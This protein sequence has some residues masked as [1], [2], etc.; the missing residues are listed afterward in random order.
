MAL[1]D[2]DLAVGKNLV[3][4]S[5]V[6]KRIENALHAQ[7]LLLTGPRRIGKTSL[8]LTLLQ[9]ND[10]DFNFVYASFKDSISSAREEVL[11]RERHSHFAIDFSDAVKTGDFDFASHLLRRIANEH[12]EPRRT[13]I[14]L[15][16][17]D[18]ALH[19]GKESPRYDQEVSGFFHDLRMMR[20]K[21]E[22]VRF[23]LSGVSTTS[24]HSRNPLLSG[25][26]NDLIQMSVGQ[27]EFSDAIELASQLLNH[28][29]SDLVANRIAWLCDG[30]PFLTKVVAYSCK[31]DVHFSKKSTQKGAINRLF[32]VV[33]QTLQRPDDP[34]CF[35]ATFDAADRML[36]D[37]KKI[38]N[39][40]LDQISVGLFDE[41]SDTHARATE[42][43]SSTLRPLVEYGI[44]ERPKTGGLRFASKLMHAW[45][46]NRQ[47]HSL[48]TN[49]YWPYPLPTKS[50]TRLTS[51]TDWANLKLG[52][53]RESAELAEKALIEFHR[54]DE[55]I[56]MLLG[57]KGDVG[58]ILSL[59][60]AEKILESAQN[61]LKRCLSDEAVFLTLLGRDQDSWAHAASSGFPFVGLGGVNEVVSRFEDQL[62]ERETL[63]SALNEF[64]EL[65]NVGIRTLGIG[66]VILN[67]DR[68]SIAPFA[69]LA[70]FS[71][72]RLSD[73][74]EIVSRNLLRQVCSKIGL[75]TSIG[76]RR[77]PFSIRNLK[78]RDRN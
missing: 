68:D 39:E 38:A 28:N 53:S 54:V 7:N 22:K 17:F 27:L 34:F 40:M 33:T 18:V 44:V 23:I 1:N 50:G 76:R 48:R 73:S 57:N 59:K 65:E 21:H 3:G 62:I 45:W 51:Y 52:E 78:K 31:D 42:R 6:I 11:L 14:I 72:R 25:V 36:A 10:E 49:D 64:P 30:F 60:L 37:R 13:V 41:K 70:F 55:E 16:D 26:F 29:G 66:R 67:D 71:G 24:K 56:A 9:K 43:Y 15:D 20:M 69:L 46:F 47:G 2:L 75:V 5:G 32:D 4:R 35:Q 61:A 8:L 77:Q 12:D 19:I 74:Q 63:V 58:S